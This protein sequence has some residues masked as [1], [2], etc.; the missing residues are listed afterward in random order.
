MFRNI[1]FVFA[2]AILFCI[3]ALLSCSGNKQYHPYS[4]EI[5]S[6]K[7]LLEEKEYEKAR[8]LFAQAS[9][10][11]RDATSIAMLGTTYYKMGDIANAESNI[12]EAEKIDKNGESYLRILG[13]KS[14]ILLKQGNPEGF[15]ALRQYADYVKNLNLPFDMHDILS[16]I[17]KQTADIAELDATIEKQ[18]IWYEN[19]I[20]NWNSGVPS[21]FSEKFWRPM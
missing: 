3:P 16:A 2:I 5:F 6:G 10:D 9:R 12:K 11:Q 18:V 14:L 15:K 4:K 17:A 20:D 7:K 21:Y 19:E 8:E 13:Y 1:N